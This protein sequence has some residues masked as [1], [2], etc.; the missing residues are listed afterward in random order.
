MVVAYA[1]GRHVA[2]GACFLYD[3][4]TWE[5]LESV[6]CSVARAAESSALDRVD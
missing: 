3:S 6:V 4:V 5:T 2:W 1:N